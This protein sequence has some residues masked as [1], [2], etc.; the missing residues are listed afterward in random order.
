MAVAIPDPTT[1]AISGMRSRIE[2]L[3]ARQL[4]VAREHRIAA[5]LASDGADGEIT[6]RNSLSRENRRLGSEVDD[7]A[8]ALWSAEAEAVDAAAR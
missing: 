3:K 1:P 4:E 5:A 6:I 8:R 2:T 7:L